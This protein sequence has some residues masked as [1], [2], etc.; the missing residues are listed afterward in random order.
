MKHLLIALTVL[1]WGVVS[2]G[3]EPAAPA[4]QPPAVAATK[5]KVLLL[6]FTPLD[7]ADRPD[8]IGRG[9]QQ[10]LSA[11]VS[12]MRVIEPVTIDA[13]PPAAGYDTT[14]AVKAA[15]DAGAQ[16][17]VYG[18]YQHADSS[19]RISGVVVDVQAGQTV[20]GLKATGDLRD[21]FDL[22]D[23]ISSQAR[24]LLRGSAPGGDATNGPAAVA[25]RDYSN[26]GPLTSPYSRQMEQLDSDAARSLDNIRMST[27]YVD[28][29]GYPYYSGYYYPYY[30]Y[31]YYGGYWPYWGFGTVIIGSS[32]HDHHDHHDGHHDD[33][34]DH[35]DHHNG[36]NFNHSNGNFN[37]SMNANHVTRF[38][39]TAGRFGSVGHAGFIRSTGGFAM[40]G[41]AVGGGFR[42]SGAAMRG[43]GG[44][45]FRGGGGMGMHGG[46]GGGHR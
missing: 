35:V 4:T 44:G 31:P 5:A 46:G 2:R 11:D 39:P 27:D 14:S 1:V 25:S 10:T 17:V 22:Q 45:G 40:R 3:A 21:I 29:W 19:V 23:A 43:G 24:R 33:H 13:P 12:H 30:G 36:N 16:Y 28:P 34:H 41:G 37:H 6:P 32:F 9:V 26:D 15:K 8:G 38:A 18:T 7:A 20:G 42:A